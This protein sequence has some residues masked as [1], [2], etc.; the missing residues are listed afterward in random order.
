[1]T[2]ESSGERV[3]ECLRAK[4]SAS[5]RDAGRVW[6]SLAN[7]AERGR[8]GEREETVSLRVISGR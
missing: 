8:G 5:G 6:L 4:C 1:V 3:V 2:R 7:E